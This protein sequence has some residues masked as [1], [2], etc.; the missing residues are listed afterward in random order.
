MMAICIKEYS[1]IG[2]LRDNTDKNKKI[3]IKTGD[4]IEC[5]DQ[6]YL[7]F[8]NVCFGHR[9]ASPAQ[10]FDINNEE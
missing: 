3:H 5:D 10:Y 2:Y 8:K 7:W 1:G 4:K 9:N 6:G